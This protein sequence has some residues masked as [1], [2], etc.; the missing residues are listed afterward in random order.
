MERIN[1][2]TPHGGDY[3]EI[4]YFDSKMNETTKE[5]AKK[6]AIRECKN[7]GDLVFETWGEM[8]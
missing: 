8:R 2:K 5:K 7:N 3:S 1:K 6:I 4:H